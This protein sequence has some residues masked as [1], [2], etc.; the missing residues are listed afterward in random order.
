MAGAIKLTGSKLAGS[1]DLDKPGR[2]LAGRVFSI[3][4][5]SWQSY[6]G[7]E[8]QWIWNSNNPNS[9]VTHNTITHYAQ[10]QTKHNTITHLYHNTITHTPTQKTQKTQKQP[11]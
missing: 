3:T 11:P 5:Q 10:P 2:L 6:N 8:Q 7:F 1:L 4:G 9:P